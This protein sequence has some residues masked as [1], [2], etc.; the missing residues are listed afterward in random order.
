MKGFRTAGRRF[1]FARGH[2]ASDTQAGKRGLRRG[3]W[4]LTLL[5]TAALFAFLP[6]AATGANPSANLDQCANGPAPSPSSDGCDTTGTD[7]VNGNLG[8]SKSVY[9]EGESIPYRMLF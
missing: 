6:A 7:W 3:L 8:A 1:T 2:Q 9:F 4:L 5:V